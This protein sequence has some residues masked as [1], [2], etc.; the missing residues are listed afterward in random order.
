MAGAAVDRRVCCMSGNRDVVH[1]GVRPAEVRDAAGLT[2]ETPDG[3]E[4]GH[5]LIRGGAAINTGGFDQAVAV[6]GGCACA[7][8]EAG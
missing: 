4:I 1:H 3:R 5:G 2:V 6:P 7:R 8:P